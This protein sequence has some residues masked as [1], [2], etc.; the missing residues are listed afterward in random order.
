MLPLLLLDTAS[1]RDADING[2]VEG[3]CLGDTIIGVDGDDVG[4]AEE[5]KGLVD[6]RRRPLRKGL[7]EGDIVETGGSEGLLDELLE[8]R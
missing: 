8:D 3:V 7:L 2:L 6:G 1:T 5:L 4:L